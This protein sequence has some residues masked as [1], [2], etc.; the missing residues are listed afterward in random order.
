M[1]LI[2]ALA[3]AIAGVA[4]WG[5]ARRMRRGLRDADSLALV[6]GI[7]GIVTAVAALVLAAGVLTGQRGLPA[8]AAVFLAEELYETGVLLLIIRASGAPASGSPHRCSAR[9]RGRGR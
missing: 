1:G 3:L 2:A 7:R 5:G 8:F 6:R 9:A 4:G